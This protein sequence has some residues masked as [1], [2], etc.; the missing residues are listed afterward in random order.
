L[1]QRHEADQLA[2]YSQ[3]QQDLSTKCGQPLS[4]VRTNVGTVE[5]AIRIVTPLGRQK[6][7]R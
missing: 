4:L 1:A 2:F 5:P 3:R 6:E 7:S